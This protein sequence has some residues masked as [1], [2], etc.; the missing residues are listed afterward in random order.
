MT[1]LTSWV[2]LA[3]LIMA[4]EVPLMWYEWSTQ[5][6][7]QCL[8]KCLPWLSSWYRNQTNPDYCTNS[9]Y[10]T[11]RLAW[12]LLKRWGQGAKEGPRSHQALSAI[13]KTFAQSEMGEHRKL[14]SRAMTEFDL[15]FHR[16]T[17]ATARIKIFRWSRAQPRDL[18]KL[19]QLTQQKWWQWN[20]EKCYGQI[21]NGMWQ[22]C[23][24]TAYHMEYERKTGLRWLHKFLAWETTVIFWE[25]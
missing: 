22:A 7:M 8:S 18:S 2:N 24:Y 5:P 14:Q 16:I 9:G 10:Y 11:R 6:R 17:L 21:L 13:V 20:G 19:L 12:D 25:G 4:Q 23:W 1:T 15:G 3:F